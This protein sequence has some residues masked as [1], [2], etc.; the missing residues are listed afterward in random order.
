VGIYLFTHGWFDIQQVLV[1]NVVVIG[2]VFIYLHM[3][4]FISNILL[5]NQYDWITGYAYTNPL[6]QQDGTIRKQFT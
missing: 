3:N 5:I 6:Q 4:G 2:W 1:V